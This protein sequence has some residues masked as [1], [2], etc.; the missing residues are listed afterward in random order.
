MRKRYYIDERVGCMAVRDR[1][2]GG[3]HE[4]GL[5]HDTTGVLSYWSGA[6]K[7]KPCLTCGHKSSDGWTIPDD[8]R[9][10]AEAE[11]KRLNAEDPP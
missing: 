3:G 6:P 11:C 10:E 4:L 8:F 7:T 9:Q 1:T 5:H 2:L